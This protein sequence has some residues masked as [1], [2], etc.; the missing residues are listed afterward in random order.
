MPR[1]TVSPTTGG[2]WHANGHERLDPRRVRALIRR[3]EG[4]V[5]GW[6][7]ARRAGASREPAPAKSRRPSTLH[8]K[9]IGQS[10]T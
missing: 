8:P 10:L 5:G 4:P 1:V 9:R 2:G 3:L 7:S 6:V